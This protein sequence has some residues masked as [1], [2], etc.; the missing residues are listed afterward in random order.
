MSKIR[1]S[2]DR[3][4]W[5]MQWGGRVI[6]TVVAAFLAL[7]RISFQPSLPLLF[8]PNLRKTFLISSSLPS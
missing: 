7:R 5:T 3:A 8:R 1:R 4:A 2:E 6:S